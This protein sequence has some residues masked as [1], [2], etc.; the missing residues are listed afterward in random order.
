MRSLPKISVVTPSYNQ[1]QFIRDAIE[2]VL[3]QDYQK[4]E[5]IIIDNCSNDN[6]IEILK[7]YSHVKWLSEPDNGQS[8][9]LNKGFN[10]ANGD[11]ILW[12]NADDMLMPNALHKFAQVVT[13]NSGLDVV[14]GHINFMDEKGTVIRTVYHIPYN[15]NM[16]LYGVY[17]PPSTGTLFRASLLKENPLDES[18]HYTMDT[19]WF[20][21]CG[22][23]LKYFLINETLSCFRISSENK[24]AEQ[25]TSGILKPQHLKERKMYREKLIQPRLPKLPSPTNSVLYYLVRF[26]FRILYYVRKCKYAYFYFIQRFKRYLPISI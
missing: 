12:L 10:I 26:I 6:T 7:K 25:I 2:S 17:M 18:Y 9:A 4:F 24:T 3:R 22:K 21:R 11:W 5:H 8:E 16:T 14:Y 1:G 19:E 23:N 13:A 15:Y 20:L